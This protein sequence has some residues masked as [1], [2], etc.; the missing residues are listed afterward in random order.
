ETIPEESAHHIMVCASELAGFGRGSR[1]RPGSG[2]VQME[3]SGQGQVALEARIASSKGHPALVL[4][5][6]DWTQDLFR[7]GLEALGMHESIA[8]RAR[9]AL[10]QS[11]GALIVCGPAGSG[12]H[13]TMRTAA[14]TLDAFTTRVA[15]LGRDSAHEMEQVTTW[16]FGDERSFLDAYEEVRREGP[17]V[18]ML[19]EIEEREQAQKALEF[20][21]ND[22]FVLA[23]LQAGDAPQGLLRLKELTGSAEAVADSVI[24]VLSQRLLRN[25]CTNCREQGRPDLEALKEMDISADEAGAWYRAVGCELC[26]DSGYRGRTGIFGML[27]VTDPVKDALQSDDVTAELI[28]EA[29]GSSAFRTMFEDGVSKVTAGITTLNE[30]RRSLKRSKTKRSKK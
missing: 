18:L 13:T 2:Q 1:L 9:A 4:R 7:A 20:A 21:K 14:G 25:L 24:C 16:S 23:S 19:P 15:V 26:L 11:R 30:V 8:R 28:R 10:A 27:I 12:A 29:A 3:L 22:G 5:L 6:P 17:D